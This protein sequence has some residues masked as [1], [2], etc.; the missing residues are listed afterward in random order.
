MKFKK[1]NFIQGWY[2]P[3]DV[4]DALIKF[5]KDNKQ[6]QELGKMTH[7]GKYGVHKNLKDSTDILIS[8]LE[9]NSDVINTYIRYLKDIYFKYTKIYPEINRHNLYL[10]EN[11]YLQKY[12]PN[13]GFKIFHSERSKGENGSSRELV[14][15]TYL[16]DVKKGGTEFKYQGLKTKAKKGLTLIWPAGFTH[17]HRGIVSKTE[18][19]Y[20]I[21]GWLNEK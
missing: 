17:I 14:W 10:K 12:K 16:N 1:E 18:T 11:M 7:Q 15:M 3:T 20:I 8:P 6:R 9:T 5:F 21:T 4:C 2:I 19:K 13:Q